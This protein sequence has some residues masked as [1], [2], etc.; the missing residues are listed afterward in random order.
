MRIAMVA[1]E[2]EPWAKT[3]GLADVVDAV[4]RALGTPAPAGLG[5]AVDVYL[6]WYRGLRPPAGLQPL[7]LRVPVGSPRDDGPRYES[8]TLWSGQADGYRLRLVQHPAS[9]D[10]AA[11]YMDADGDFRDNAARFTLLGRTAL[12]AIRAEARP[13]DIIHGHDWQAGP[14]LLSLRR[15]YAADP[16]LARSATMLTCHNLAYHGWTPSMDAWQLDLPPDVGSPEGV[17]LLREAIYTADIVNTVSPSYARE[18]LTP[19][20]GGGLHEALRD[21]GERYLGIINGIDT[22]L[23]DP[24]T[25]PT[26][27]APYSV[28][29]LAQAPGPPGKAAARSALLE[30]HGLDGDGPLLGVIGRL[31]PQK[32]FDLVA[33]GAPALLDLGARLVVLGTGDRRLVA[34][35]LALAAER[36]ERVVVMD[37]FDPEEARRIYA[38]VD[39]FLMPSR[40]EP[41]GQGQ[42][43]AMRY[44]TPPVV[45]RVGGL[46][47]T[48]VDADADPAQGTGFVF[49]PAE[50]GALVAAVTRALAAWRDPA[51]FKDIQ[52]RG[53]TRDHS[54]AIPARQYE[55]AYR[56]ILGA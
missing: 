8:V 22:V 47:D 27:P 51:R 9:F 20:F 46:S 26:L 41:C 19:E 12:E 55:E 30:R 45:R 11:F 5:H 6:P 42:M 13:V 29:D 17:D 31:D 4:S 14:A 43:I 49:G 44:G 24:A 23:W 37:R 32:G 15:R 21:R 34:D 39:L 18:S 28:A 16:L 50:P 35:L 36:P 52:V 25:D 40:F 1:S 56:R 48:V 2:C 38:G 54:W 10:R 7:E 53:M 33:D 3:G